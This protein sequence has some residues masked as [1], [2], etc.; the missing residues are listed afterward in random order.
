MTISTYSFTN[1][2]INTNYIVVVVVSLITSFML[3]NVVVVSTCFLFVLSNEVV[4]LGNQNMQ[5]LQGFLLLSLN[6]FIQI[7]M[8]PLPQSPIRVNHSAEK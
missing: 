2:K 6:R 3:A 5:T 7:I 4:M 8:F 1:R